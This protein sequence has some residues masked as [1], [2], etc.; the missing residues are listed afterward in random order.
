MDALAWAIFVPVI[1]WMIRLIAYSVTREKLP[2]LRDLC[3]D[4]AEYANG[5][6]RA[7]RLLWWLWRRHFGAFGTFR[8]FKQRRHAR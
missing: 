1:Y 8:Q 3:K 4:F 5:H 7:G 2:R 6:E